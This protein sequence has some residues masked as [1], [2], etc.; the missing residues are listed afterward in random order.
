[1]RRTADCV[2][3]QMLQYRR[4]QSVAAV[5]QTGESLLACIGPGEGGDRIV[6]SAARLAARLDVPWHAL[7]IDTPAMQRLSRHQRQHILKHVK[8]AQDMGAETATLSGSDPVA[9]VIAYAR[10]HNLFRVVVG[11]DRVRR[12]RPWY[13]S[14]ADRIGKQAPDLEVIQVARDEPHAGRPA[15]TRTDEPWL[16]RLKAPW[17]SYAMS[18]LICGIAAVLAAPLHS[19]FELAT[20]AMLLLLAVVVVSVRY[21]LGPSVMAAFLNVAAF[22]FFHVSPRFSLSVSDIQYLL[23]FAVML[24]VGLVIATLTTGAKYQARVASLREQRVRALYELSRDLSGALMPEQ[25]AT[26][27]QR[28][29]AAEFGARS[30]VLLADAGRRLGDPVHT[31]EAGL[32]VDLGVAQWALD[33]GTEAGVGTDTLPGSPIRYVPLQVPMRTRGVLALELRDPS[34]LMIPEQGRLLDTFAR[35]IAIALERIHYVEVAQTTTV[36]MESERLRNSLLSAISHDLRTPLAAL[37]GLADSLSMMQPPPTGEQVMVA[38]AVR[39][40][41]LR[42]NALVNNLLDMARL[43]SGAVKLNRQWQ[44]LEDIVG[45]SLKSVGSTIAGHRVRIALPE[46]LPLLEFDAVLIERVLSNLLENAAK[47]TP[48]GST[49]GIGAAVGDRDTITIRVE[50]DGPGLPL[51]KEEAIFK[52]FER[53]QKESTT[54]GVGLGLAI[55]RAIV[56]AHGGTMWAENRPEG[57]ARFTF[58]LPRG[59]PPVIDT[60]DESPV[61]DERQR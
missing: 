38:S 42:M 56:E 18:T 60:A 23:T 22:D 37:I 19:V 35:L 11:R 14:F 27:S 29:A 33:H 28:F 32:A 6:R 8:L 31:P 12:W 13:R 57:G 9:T 51:G 21:G 20:I 41:A 4:A 2:D 45:S 10:D 3:S 43:Q 53:G 48:A 16:A 50:D 1:M 7:S 59:H 34:R 30:A 61:H 5:W 49:I 25:I 36:Q 55:S 39:K 24:G 47:F 58:S 52:K 44:S 46:D 54:P 15:D 17:Q 40:E 26:I